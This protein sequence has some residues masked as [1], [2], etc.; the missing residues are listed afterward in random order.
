[1]EEEPGTKRRTAKDYLASAEK[2]S[3]WADAISELSKGLE[4]YPDNAE[5][6]GKRGFYSEL[7]GCYEDAIR[8][9]TDIIRLEPETAK[10]YDNRGST[11]YMMKKYDEA[12]ADFTKALE[13]DP[14]DTM[15]MKNVIQ[16]V[17]LR[18]PIKRRS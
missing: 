14:A 4:D 6:L 1:M 17:R 12:I 15:G 18:L 3:C 10:S 13:L 11:Y 8:D 7:N 2:E 5:L 9:Y 16:K